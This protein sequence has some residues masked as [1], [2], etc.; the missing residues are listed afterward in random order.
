[1]HGVRQSH[2]LLVLPF[3]IFLLFIASYKQYGIALIP[4]RTT[5]VA[6]F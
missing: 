5:F 2:V 4:L 1:M 3:I 6:L